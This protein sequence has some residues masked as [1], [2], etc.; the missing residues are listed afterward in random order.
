MT[1]LTRT[2]V[3]QRIDRE[4]GSAWV[5][6]VPDHAEIIADMAC[7]AVARFT[8]S[9]ATGLAPA[10]QVR[11]HGTEG[12]LHYDRGTGV[13]SG[14]RRGDAALAPIE[15][16][17]AKRRQWAVE[18]E[19]VDS[20]RHRTPV[21]RTSFEDGV[22]YMEFAKAVGRSAATGRAVALPLIP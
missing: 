3:R 4:T 8:F 15:V 10:P 21:R 12:T 17:D 11:L 13:L 6:T 7:G 18:E 16:P 2:V 20:V 22:R 14:G 5:A 1:A 9:A 19:F